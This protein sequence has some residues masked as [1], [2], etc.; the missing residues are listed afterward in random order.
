MS[1]VQVAFGA[2]GAPSKALEGF[3]RKNGVA[4]AEVTVKADDKGTEYCWAVV[5]ETGRPAAEVCISIMSFFRS[6]GLILCS[7]R[8]SSV[9]VMAGR[10]HASALQDL[11]FESPDADCGRCC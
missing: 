11:N 9:D 10:V 5:R 4:A 8:L 7:V 2:D 1:H 6:P 3:C